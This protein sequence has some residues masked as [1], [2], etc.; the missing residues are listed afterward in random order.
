MSVNILLNALENEILDRV[1]EIS[2]QNLRRCMQCGTCTAVCPM[3][4]HMDLT[5][6]QTVLML[7]HGQSDPVLE[8]RTP[9]LCASCHS[10]QVRCPRD[11]EVTR[12]MEAVRQV[13]LRANVDRIDPRQIPAET[14]AE[15]PQIALIAGLRK[16][17]A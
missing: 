13:M 11:I 16:L 17:T 14:V 12:V 15:A 7:L 6:R 5:P 8:S 9:W 3:A 2:G 4:E 10:C 1:A